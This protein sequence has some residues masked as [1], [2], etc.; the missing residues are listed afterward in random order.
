M[1]GRSPTA[2]CFRFDAQMDWWE[3][4]RSLS[5]Q[6]IRVM[7][8]VGSWRPFLSPP[9][10]DGMAMRPTITQTIAGGCSTTP[11]PSRAW[12]SV[13]H[14]PRARFGGSGWLSM[15]GI[16]R[17]DHPWRTRYWPD[18][19]DPLRPATWGQLVFG[20]KP[21]YV[22]DPADTAGHDGHPPGTRW[23]HGG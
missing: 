6:P 2:D 4:D 13:D 1:W 19:M 11:S 8:A 22:P 20:L 21:A 7:G 10:P 15:T 18:A 9:M 16:A 12:G 17:P 5:R 3:P 23:R 14:P